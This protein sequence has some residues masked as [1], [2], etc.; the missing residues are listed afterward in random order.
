MAWEPHV[1]KLEFIPAG[2]CPPFWCIIGSN[3]KVAHPCAQ[4]LAISMHSFAQHLHWSGS[5][6]VSA[7]KVLFALRGPQHPRCYSDEAFN[8]PAALVIHHCLFSGGLTITSGALL[9]LS[10]MTQ[11]CRDRQAAS[12]PLGLISLSSFSDIP[13]VFLQ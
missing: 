9:Q 7:Q 11:G 2:C 5:G 12:S 10:L 3:A 8:S 6:S 4:I 13:S 1:R